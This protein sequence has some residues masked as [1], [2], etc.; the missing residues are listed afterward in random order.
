M[1]RFAISISLAGLVAFAAPLG[2]QGRGRNT[3]GVPPGQRP[4]A[5]MCRIWVDGVP[6]GQQPAP[7]DCVSAVRNRP[8][9]GRVI[10]GDESA[11]PGR[12]FRGDDDKFKKGK[13]AKKGE[14]DH[15]E[16]IDDDRDN[17]DEREGRDRDRDHDD[18]RDDAR[19]PG[20][21]LCVDRDRDGRCDPRR[22]T[23][24]YPAQLPDMIGAV[25]IGRGQRSAEVA[26][27]GLA[28]ATPR[29]FDANRDGTPERVHWMSAS[30]ELVQVWSDVNRDGRADRVEIFEAGRRVNTINRPS[31]P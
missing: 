6:P 18:A 26:S 21:D 11:S 12:G 24:Q 13:H 10:F 22:P 1:N 31:R 30:G 20:S 23:T 5:G 19:R 4:P 3:N 27:W 28:G 25:L 9:N 14:R 15:D 17:R 16:D 2:A 7:T 29:L 8:S